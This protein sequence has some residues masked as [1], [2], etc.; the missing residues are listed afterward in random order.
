MHTEQAFAKI[1]L[2]LHVL[3]KRSDGYHELDS[4]VAFAEVGDELVFQHADQT[5]LTLGGP[6]AK[7]LSTGPDNLVL[8]AIAAL[9]A[10]VELP[11]VHVHLWKNLPI[12]SGI[13]GGS[14]D[15]AAA[16][17]GMLRFSNIE[18]PADQ[19]NAIGLS[20]GAD[21]PVCIAS[22]YCRMTGIGE[23]ITRLEKPLAVAIVLVNPMQACSTADVFKRLGLKRG[24]SYG[25]SLDV[26]TPSTWRNDL[27]EP[28]R[29]ILP[30]ISSVLGALANQENLSDVRMSGSGA[31]CFGLALSLTAAEQAAANLR[32]HFPDWWCVAAGLR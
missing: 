18:M 17:R 9:A 10:G 1:N 2:A 23:Q 29:A 16:L 19:L 24:E 22:R 15:A 31:T 26:G 12:A 4:I 32:Q 27:T 6:F 21:V 25:Q 28:A 3:G 8:R 11:P 5:Y 30:E 14:T 20:I 7:G 13:G